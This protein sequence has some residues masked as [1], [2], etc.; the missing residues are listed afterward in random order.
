MKEYRLIAF[1]LD[2]TLTE[3]KRGLIRSFVH[4][5]SRM[6][7]DYGPEEKMTRFIGPPLYTEWKAEFGFSDAEADRALSY[8]HEYFD[9]RGWAEN[10][11]YEGIEDVLKGLKEQGKILVLA[12]SKPQIFAEKIMAHFGL[13]GYFDCL[14]GAM[15]DKRADKKSEVLAAALSRFPDVG[16][17]DCILVGDRKFDAEG[18]A[19]CGIDSLGV[20]YGHGSREEIAAAG[21]TAIAKTVPDLLTLLSN[22]GK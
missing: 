11:V 21:F 22:T 2:G 15:D 14:S 1:D 19:I 8:F 13:D 9:N 6:G 10:E 12:T 7:V 18:A 4:A 3:P 17:S 16:K 5:L 20:L